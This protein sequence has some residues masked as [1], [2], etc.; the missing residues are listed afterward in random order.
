MRE[1]SVLRPGKMSAFVTA[2]PKQAVTKVGPDH[3]GSD[4][5]G[6]PIVA[7]FNTIIQFQ[8]IKKIKKT[9]GSIENYR[10]CLQVIDIRFTV[11]YTLLFR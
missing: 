2:V 5:Y 1:C 6:K 4:M 7:I 8:L 10:L 3:L 9:N 11:M